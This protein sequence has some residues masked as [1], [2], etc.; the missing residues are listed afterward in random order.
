VPL[1]AQGTI[2]IVTPCGSGQGTGLTIPITVMG[3]PLEVPFYVTDGTGQSF[4][5]RHQISE[6]VD[7]SFGAFTDALGTSISATNVPLDIASINAEL[8]IQ[9]DAYEIASSG[10]KRVDQTAQ[11]STLPDIGG[12]DGVLVASYQRTIGGTQ[13]VVKREPY[14]LGPMVIDGGV[15]RIP[16]TTK[17]TYAPT[18]ISWSEDTMGVTGTADFV[19]ARLDVTRPDPVG[20][21]NDIEFVRTI[22]AAHGTPNLRTPQ[23]PIA[24]YN[25]IADDTIAGSLALVS[26]TGGYDGARSKVFAYPSITDIAP[27]NGTATI[28]YTG[29]APR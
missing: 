20:G 14:A 6:N 23:L 15:A 19:L 21:P 10:T 24:I 11:T 12:V 17:V 9:A 29:A 28:S 16:Y 25:P 3:C 13:L 2:K 22:V 7:L 4:L 27:M 18:G 8:R 26:V 1:L 5:V